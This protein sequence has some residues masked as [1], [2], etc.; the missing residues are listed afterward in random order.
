MLS[1]QQKEKDLKRSN[2][3]EPKKT[4]F[5]TQN[6]KRKKLITTNI[7]L[8]WQLRDLCKTYDFLTDDKKALVE[9]K[10]PECITWLETTHVNDRIRNHFLADLYDEFV[11]FNR[12]TTTGKRPNDDGRTNFY[13]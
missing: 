11:T 10:V 1:W 6:E 4:V 9:I 8:A 13:L 2:E 5:Q 3:I 7:Q 12:Y